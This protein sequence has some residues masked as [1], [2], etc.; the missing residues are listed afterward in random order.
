[1]IQRAWLLLLAQLPAAPSSARVALWRRL[2]AAGAASMQNGAWILPHSEE[3]MHLVTQLAGAVRSQGG[4]AALFTTAAVN[5][6]EQEAVLTR[7]R[8][9]RAREYDEFA[10]RIEGVL[11]EIEKETQLQKF[12]FAELEEIESDL[13]KMTTWLGKI[14]AR[15][16]FPDE[17]MKDATEKLETC[18]AALSVFAEEVYAYEGVSAPA[19]DEPVQGG[20]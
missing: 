11:A 10:T 1:M 2:R 9:D 6:T 4:S 13:D 12:T 18:G 8:S 17:R 15:D 14:R 5:Q 3:H 19:D 16:F 20:A 7:F